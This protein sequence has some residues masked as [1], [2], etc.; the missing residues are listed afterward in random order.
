[1]KKCRYC[2]KQSLMKISRYWCDDC[3]DISRHWSMIKSNIPC[4]K[5]LEY[6]RKNHPLTVERK[7]SDDGRR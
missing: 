5:H 4:Y 2:G 6:Y 7:E 3:M 1:M